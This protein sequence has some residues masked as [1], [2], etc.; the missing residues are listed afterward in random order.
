MAA[1]VHMQIICKSWSFYYNE[2]ESDNLLHGL[3]V[4]T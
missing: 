4:G 1:E 3:C 2:G